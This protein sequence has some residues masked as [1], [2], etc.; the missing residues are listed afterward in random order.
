V[1]EII[2]TSNRFL[3]V[4]LTT[5][6]VRE[7]KATDED[8]Q[9]Y[10][11]GKG[12]GLKYIYDR[13]DLNVDPLGEGNILAFMMGVMISTGAP[14]TGRFAAITKSPLTG[15]MASSS[16]GGP[17]GIAYKT[18]GY[19]GLLISGKAEKPVYL[20][21]DENGVQFE[22][23]SDLWGKETGET[24]EGLNLSKNDGALVIGPAGENQ[25][26]YANIRSGHRFLGRGGM[27]AVMGAKNLKAIVAKGKAYKIVPK[28]PDKFKRVRQRSLKYIKNSPFTSEFYRNFG[29]RYNVTIMN[30]GCILP[31]YNFRDGSDER[32]KAVSGEAMR[33]RYHPKP[34]SCPLC[35]ILCGHKGKY[36][37]DTSH[38]LPEYET[39]ALFGPNLGNFDPD[40]ITEWN[41]ICG[42][43]GIDTMSVAAT[44]AYVMEAGEKGL[45]RTDLTF[46]SPEGI[47]EMLYDIGHRRGQGDELAN[48]SRWLSQKYGGE[49]F[50]I[51]VKGLELPAYDPR[52]SWGHGLNY[53]VANRGGCH[54]S[55][56][57]V[58]LEVFFGLMN[59]H[60]T[61]NKEK[62]VCFLE[63]LYS[64]INSLHCCQFT[65]YAYIL[66]PPIPKLLPTLMLRFS[67]TFFP[68][69]SQLLMDWSVYSGFFESITGLKM[70]KLDFLKAGDRIHVLERYMNT[71]MGISRKDDTLPG[72][73]LKEGRTN[74]PKKR[75]VPLEKMVT[76]YYKV[77]GYDQNG[78]PTVKTL[79]KL[80][81]PV[82]N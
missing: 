15:I 38:Q 74:D 40:I 29:T 23:A 54:L 39:I 62:W 63:S 30:K 47:S 32:A 57:P 27:G 13:M 79:R 48:G 59:P 67:M 10:L 41:D 66:E 19:D 2:G 71:K 45:M 44:I 6:E 61:Y 77:R 16:C 60:S 36:P 7:F 76:N 4:N 25:V 12:L 33:E 5:R 24:Q 51:H 14:C 65:A 70:S 49:D 80:R 72:R 21:I 81:I 50:A 8:R 9:L 3:E 35:V 26:L 82:R 53:A 55:S 75:V 34:N 11:G 58:A 18:A 1:K 42:E 46:D 78:I 52:G 20:V 37:D 69:L 28:N 17:F 22:D 68:R 73:F 43:I 64:G 56:F 31:V